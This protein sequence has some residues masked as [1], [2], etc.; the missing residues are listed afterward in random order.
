MASASVLRFGVV[1]LSSRALAEHK[2]ADRVHSTLGAAHTPTPT[3]AFTL[4]SSAAIL[5]SRDRRTARGKARKPPRRSPVLTG[6]F[7]HLRSPSQNLKESGRQVLFG[8]DTR[9]SGGSQPICSRLAR[10]AHAQRLAMHARCTSYRAGWR[11]PRPPGPEPARSDPHAM[12]MV[13]SPGAAVRAERSGGACRSDF[14]ASS[15]SRAS[16]REGASAI[17]CSRPFARGCRRFGSA[18]RTFAARGRGMQRRCG[19]GSV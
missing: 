1:L 2:P 15:A 8:L 17:S 16:A 11:D 10:R 7:A 14:P 6:I 3:A 5:R 12:A 9:F 13:P 4:R 18:S 19:C